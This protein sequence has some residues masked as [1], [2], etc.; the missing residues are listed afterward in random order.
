[1]HMYQPSCLASSPPRLLNPQ[2]CLHILTPSPH[3]YTHQQEGNGLLVG[4]YEADCI[5]KAW[6]D[7]PPSE[8][9]WGMELFP[10]KLERIENNLLAAMELV[11]ALGTVGF[12][13][14]TNGPT[15]WTGDSMPRVGRT[16][17]PGYYDFNSLTY[18]IAQVC[19]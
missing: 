6:K 15:I 17:I 3:L 18:G 13:N 5:V 8:L 12:I 14:C 9:E 11:P 16:S 1:M 10:D 4:P 7:G 19:I 2:P